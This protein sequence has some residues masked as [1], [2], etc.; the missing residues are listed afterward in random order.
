[1]ALALGA[2]CAASDT[3]A[4]TAPGAGGGTEAGGV[5]GSG[6]AGANA[7][8]NV[9][10]SG[11]RDVNV[12][13]GGATPGAGGATSGGAP[14][15]AGSRTGNGGTA[16]SAGGA[17]TTGGTGNAGT[18][19]TSSGGSAV[20]GSGGAGAPSAKLA[21]A[22]GALLGEYY[23]DGSVADT[24]ARIGRKPAIHLT[25]VAVGDDFS[26]V[27]KSDASSG[28]IALISWEPDGIDFNDIVSGKLDSMLMTQ[29]SGAKGVG[30]PFFL[31]FAAE[32]N[33]DEAW[34]GNDAPLY[35]SGYRH[36]HDLFVAAGATN[37]VWAWCPNVTDVDGSNKH[38]LDHYP[39]DGYV[40]WTGVDGYNW[41][42]G[43]GFSWQSF[44]DVFARI[45]PILA[46][47]GKP[48]LIG[49]MASDENGGDKGMWIDAMIPTL[50]SDFPLIKA[51]AWF[52]VHK[53]RSWQINSSPASLAAYQRFAKD[54]YMNP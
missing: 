41:G 20:G 32:M 37:V 42:S 49:E 52:D 22:Q 6:N 48:I 36:I 30:S 50:K 28:K 17:S 54:P 1:M 13:A 7:A 19:G 40:D 18:A 3:G 33:G 11:G 29:A 43:Q 5:A 46:G 44:H 9:N 51:L 25:Y 21:P 34:S 23:G 2:A 16:T 26:S 24:E 45:Y 15:V 38:T 47:K 14:G 4:S 35:V 31:D 27:A 53:E 39:G 10:G 12:S 8:G